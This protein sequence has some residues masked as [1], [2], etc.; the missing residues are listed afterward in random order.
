MNA[1]YSHEFRYFKSLAGAYL[2]FIQTSGLIS[3]GTVS[4]VVRGGIP[5][6]R[7]PAGN[8][9]GSADSI[10]HFFL[11]ILS[12]LITFP[13]NSYRAKCEFL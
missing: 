3:A 7:L 13:A 4:Q 2:N 5:Q 11:T 12:S 8:H 6:N 10:V 1:Q 9:V